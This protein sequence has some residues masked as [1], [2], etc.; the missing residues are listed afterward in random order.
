M[1]KKDKS[2]ADLKDYRTKLP[3]DVMQWKAILHEKGLAGVFE[4]AMKKYGNV[5]SWRNRTPDSMNKYQAAQL[6]HF[7]KRKLGEDIDPESGL[8][9]LAHE[10]WC[11]AT[12]L[13]FYLDDLDNNPHDLHKILQ[14]SDY[15]THVKLH[16][17]YLKKHF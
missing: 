15:E 9:H 8:P 16:E 12:Q 7:R 4:F 2:K 1:S 6:R 13:E 5:S 14:S 3:M 17:E 11:I 10:L